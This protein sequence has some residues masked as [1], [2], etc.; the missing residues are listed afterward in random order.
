MLTAAAQ[1]VTEARNAVEQGALVGRAK[2]QL[3]EAEEIDRKA[4]ELRERSERLR[5]AARGTDEVLS[6]LVAKAGVPLRVEPVDQRMRLTLETRRGATCYAELSDGERWRIA[7][8]IAIKA[9]GPGGEI[10]LS[11]A[12]WQDLDTTNRRAIAEQAKAGNILIYTA[13]A[14]EG[15]LRAEIYGDGHAG[16][17]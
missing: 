3:A 8:D 11:Q 10:T 2:K 12:A 7:I 16:V 5:Q 9:V 1:V 6:G 4:A 14:D 13:C 17:H 15:D